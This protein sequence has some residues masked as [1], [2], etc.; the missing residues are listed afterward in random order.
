MQLLFQD[1]GIASKLLRDDPNRYIYE[2]VRQG[3]DIPLPE[4]I[5]AGINDVSKRDSW[6]KPATSD[7]ALPT[8]TW[9]EHITRRN[10]CLELRQKLA[11]G[12]INSINDLITHNLNIRQLAQDIIENCYDPELVWAFYQTVTKITILDS[13]CGSGAFLFSALNILESLYEACFEQMQI[14]LDESFIPQNESCV[15][16][17]ENFR[18]VLEQVNSHDN[19]NYFI[20]KSIVINNLYG[21]D[22]MQE[23]T[24][25]CKL[26]L[27]L[28]LTS[29][30]EPDISKPN[31]GIEP[32]PDIDFNIRA[33]NTLVGFT[34]LDEVRDAIA[35]DNSG[36]LK[37]VYDNSVIEQIEV[38]SQ[39]VDRTFQEFRNLQIALHIDSKELG[40]KKAELR[41]SVN[42]LKEELDCYLAEE[43]EMELSKRTVLFE[44]WKE[45]HQPFHWFV[46]FYKIIR[47]GGFDVIIGNPPYV[48]YR[49]VKS[50]YK[51]KQSSYKSEPTNN[52]Y[53][54]CIERAA[55]LLRRSGYFGMIIPAGVLGLD[56]AVSLRKVLLKRF[57]YNFCSTYAIRPSKLF[58]GVDQRLC[59]YIGK[60]NKEVESKILTTRYHH[61]NLEER[62]TLFPCLEYNKSFH[63]KRLERIP[64]V[65]SSEA[66]S[67]LAK[68]ES[69]NGRL[70]LNYFA[71]NRH[72]CLMHYHRSPRYWIRAM[73]FE[74]YFKSPTRTRSVHHF[75][76]LYFKDLNEGKVI[77][78]LLN[79]SLF[80]FWFVSVGNGR[81]ITGSDVENFPVGEFSQDIL[82][83]LPDIFD[84][85]MFDYKAN[86]FL[87]VRQDCE[88]QEFRPSLSKPTIDKI[89]GL[90]ARYYGFTD[91]E[92]DFIIN[93]DTKYRMGRDSGNE[94]DN[95]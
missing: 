59:I 89:D 45:S 11:D 46:E 39:T 38:S 71:S 30:V 18:Q 63:Y 58:D 52:L 12:E 85:L 74:Q 6:N 86:S 81:N 73:D 62:N 56:D 5:E 21:V 32:L 72:G 80:F 29:Q 28:K 31:N 33:G 88:F 4:V 70:V 15:R 91:K 90:L 68:L 16:V 76:N 61:W 83:N 24:E 3:V 47:Q 17:L 8:E 67:I 93:Y 40:S 64:Q 50:T 65:G 66:A 9:R 14:F 43:Y 7:Y 92:L 23:A 10:R 82:K 60:F 49:L 41:A 77:G 42:Q 84:Q 13:T 36:Q 25:I 2:V 35:K 27:F 75:R 44:R 22:I 51:L 55:I 34:S 37:L 78:A 53:A 19:R 54:F 79:S 87:R 48:E 69:K 94:N 26:R 1:N 57:T 95:E 20:I